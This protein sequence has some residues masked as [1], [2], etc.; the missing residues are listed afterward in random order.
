MKT[1]DREIHDIERRMA[2]RRHEVADTARAAQQRAK[3]KLLSPTGLAAAAGVGFVV[4]SLLLR[5]KPTVVQ[6]P[7]GKAGKAAS[8]LGVLMPIGLAIVRAQFGSPAGLAQFVLSKMQASSSRGDVPRMTA[9]ARA[10][11]V[12]PVH[13]AR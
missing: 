13:P 7:Q 6:V 3:R 2:R 5:R 1:I 9:P 12:P 11:T 10:R 4:T 8:L